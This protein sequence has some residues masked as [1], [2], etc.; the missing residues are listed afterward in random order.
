[1]DEKNRDRS[2]FAHVRRNADGSWD[3]PQSLL[4]HLLG[5]AERARDFAQVF[6]SGEWAYAAGLAH[7]VG[8]AP[9]EWQDYL[10]DKS[11][12][13]EEAGAGAAA[14]K[15]DHSAPGARFIEDI[16]GK[17]HGRMLSYCIAGHHAGLADWLGSQS[18]LAFRL[19]NAKTAGIPSIYKELIAPCRPK[20]APRGFEPSGLDLS[21]WVRM[22]FS[23]LVDAD[24]LDTESYM[25]PD[26]GGRRGQY[27][28]IPELL[29]RFDAY[30]SV[31]CA[32]AAAEADR[33]VNR[34]RNSVLA[35]CRTAAAL[36]PG[37]FSL[38]VPTG[39][40]KTLSS[41]A[42][43]LEHAKRHGKSRVIYVIPYT[44]IIEQNVDIFR[45][46]LGPEQVVEHHSNLDD[47][48]SSQQARLAAEN[49][50]APVIVTTTVQFFESLFTAKVS[51]ARKLH[52]IANSVVILDEAQL[53]PVEY[54]E[55]ILEA[56]RLLKDHY[57][58]SFLFCTATQP[59]F[60]KRPDA[61]GFKGLPPGSVREIVGDVAA[62]F[63]SLKRV[64]VSIPADLRT[65]AGWDE[66]SGDLCANEQVLCVV[67]DRRSC[68][69]LHTL[70]PKPC[71][72]LS[73][74]MCAQHRSDVIERIKGE[75]KAGHGIRVVS[76]QLV[77]AGVDFSFPVVYRALAGLDSIAQASGRCN[78]E[79]RL[80]EEGKLGKVVVF[81]PPRPAP[82][83][84]L[85]KASDTARGMLEGGLRDPID[86]AVFGPYFSELYWKANSLDAKGVIKALTP[87]RDECGMNFRS[88]S[89]SFH[90]VDDGGQKT[91][92]VPYGE[93]KS[94][95][96][97][98]KK[99]GPERR[100]LRKLQRYTVNVYCNQFD[101]LLKRG[102]IEPVT[103]ELFALIC[104]IEYD[105]IVGLRIDDVL[106]DPNAYT[107]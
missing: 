12:F 4:D 93:G 73:A 79:G 7:D 17:G 10:R 5:T 9:T 84:I 72:H 91:I 35:E 55:P 80:N 49:W 70:M 29:A 13:D 30:M 59:L 57:K 6:G 81:V 85:R 103:P 3:E 14:G 1:M 88:V 27:L 64:E 46:A 82:L 98:L 67:S 96:A 33:P 63:D 90:I 71:V 61:S 75:L 34:A 62:L 44:S 92:L 53:L 8:K 97:N 42:F 101:D 31:K 95:I 43:G 47:D 28:A 24:F 11:G 39:G 77:E 22:L 19:Q 50:D 52:N 25:V 23:C 83:G 87:D 48:D 20:A 102:S 69:E 41:L 107:N 16:F 68:R 37:F 21:L 106:Y 60:E 99:F 2:E 54:L 26:K 94:L 36:A 15:M 100:I 65:S 56:M 18:A 38:T 74:L 51:R 86:Q 40:G 45:K 66:I 32:S 76:T 78:R 105:A 104:G 89:E 58:V